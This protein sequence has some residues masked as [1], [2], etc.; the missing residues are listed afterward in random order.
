MDRPTLPVS[1]RIRQRRIEQGRTQAVVAGLC[2][3]STE[4]LSQIERGLK[5][6]ARAVMARLAA[7]LG[8]PVGTLMAGADE[9][10]APLPPVVGSRVAQALL[11]QHR[12]PSTPSPPAAFGTG[13]RACGTSGSPPPPDSRSRRA[14]YPT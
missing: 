5:T 2:G 11:V 12:P 4:Y 1:E 6:P 7:E 10:M 9:V 3:I 13:S 8:L 14:S